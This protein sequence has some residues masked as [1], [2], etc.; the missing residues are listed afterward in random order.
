[1]SIQ[2]G[3]FTCWLISSERA[4][5][6]R[7]KNGLGWVGGSLLYEP[8]FL[9]VGAGLIEVGEGRHVARR[10]LGEAPR[11][12]VPVALH[13]GER[14]HAFQQHDR[15]DDDDEGAGVQALGR[16]IAEQPSNDHP[17]AARLP[18]PIA[19]FTGLLFFG[20]EHRSAPWRSPSP[21]V[22]IKP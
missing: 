1:V 8:A 13:E 9:R 12:L 4:R 20:R 7:S 19:R 22:D 16:E 17:S 6:R 14:H 18:R 11:H 3:R 15:R 2:N 5:S 10:G 21:L